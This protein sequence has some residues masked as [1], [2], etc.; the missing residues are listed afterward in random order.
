MSETEVQSKE[1]KEAVKTEEVKES[2]KKAKE[3]KESSLYYFYTTGC[4][5]CKKADPVID[6]LIA[7]GHDILKLDLANGDNQKLQN[8]VKAKYNHQCG[9]PYF[10]DGDTGN[11][12]CG[13]RD[14]DT[15]TKWAKG[16]EI[17]APPKP[18]GPPPKVPFHGASDKEMKVWKKEYKKWLDDNK[19]MENLLSIEQILSRPRPKSDPPPRP[20]PNWSD[21][22]FDD[23]K[24]K[25]DK[26][27]DEND[28]LP[29]LQ[30]GEQMVNTFKQRAQQ[31]APGTPGAQQPGV[32]AAQGTQL[33]QR[34]TTLE[35][36]VD[37]M[38]KHFGVK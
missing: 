6:E 9:T 14:K 28:H 33:Q 15:L 7:E 17:P 34:L 29:N 2:P 35:E 8:E 3:T 20:M 24:V 12:I 25:W 22:E 21:K 30:T 23:W 5:W 13:F 10:V 19:H 4:G 31:P 27:K 16:E 38:M 18:T 11:V 32:T 1:V 36:K 26:W 37:K